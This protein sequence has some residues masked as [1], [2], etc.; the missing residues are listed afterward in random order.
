MHGKYNKLHRQE[1][2]NCSPSWFG[3]L[4]RA[5]SNISTSPATPITGIYRPHKT[6]QA[7]LR[8]EPLPKPFLLPEY[9]CGPL[10]PRSHPLLLNQI[11]F[12]T[13]LATFL[14]ASGY[15]CMS[16]RAHL[17]SMRVDHSNMCMFLPP[18]FQTPK[19]RVS[20]PF[21]LARSPLIHVPYQ[22]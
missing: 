8:S 15:V 7:T 17:L 16:T 19:A 1:L 9:S 3:Y 14:N 10:L 21:S 13:L 6:K 2:Y 18:R 20:L 12:Y 5:T 11:E 22:K 4:S